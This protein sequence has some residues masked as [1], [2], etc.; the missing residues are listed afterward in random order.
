MKKLIILFLA[1]S[2]TSCVSM[3]QYLSGRYNNI[4]N[5][6]IPSVVEILSV[7]VEEEVPNNW[8]DSFKDS[9]ENLED[10]KKYNGIGSGFIY[11]S[12]GTEYYIITNKHVV[13]SLNKVQVILYDD[14][15][16]LGDV[17]GSDDRF[18]LAVIKI[19]SNRKL[20]PLKLNLDDSFKVGD[21]IAVVGSP[22]G[23]S[24]SISMGIISHY[25]RYGGPENN[26]SSY[27][28]T[29][30]A[31]NQG[32]SGGPMLNLKG[33]VIGLNT[34]ILAPGGGSIGLGFAVPLINI[35]K[36]ILEIIESGYVETPWLGVVSNNVP[37]EWK[38]Y[39]KG[40]FIDQVVIDSPAYGKILPGDI[41]ISVNSK[42]IEKYNDLILNISLL[43]PG[44]EVLFKILRDNKQLTEIVV[45]ESNK[46]YAI[47]LSKELFPGFTLTTKDNNLSVENVLPKSI[48]QQKGF[49][50][51][52][53]IKSINNHKPAS[54]EEFYNNLKSGNNL[55]VISRDEKEFELELNY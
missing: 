17:V 53:I 2:I 13:G 20:K 28:Q 1:I 15:W 25:G 54:L 8:Y 38:N 41:V 24:K 33:E 5:N 34:W 10:L 55:I 21:F 44:S 9:E 3:D 22:M 49:K 48:G 18:D 26:I 6:T 4:Y 39:I 32:N 36:S 35:N 12:N 51:G 42:K 23:Y 16:V 31:I 14:T 43:S 30:A 46:E 47:K 27:I 11:N 19:H 52:D 40:A 37:D 7:G 29:D 50:V 45:L